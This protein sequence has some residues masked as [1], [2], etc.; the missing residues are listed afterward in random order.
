MKRLA[1]AVLALLMMAGFGGVARSERLKTSTGYELIYDVY[2]AS[3]PAA[4]I[5]MHGKNG[6]HITPAM[7]SFAERVQKAGFTVYLPR[8]PWSRFWDG[9]V[10]DAVSAVDALV[11]LAAKNGKKVFV[12]GQSQG[13][14]FTQVYRPSDPPPAVI[15]KVMTNPGGLLDLTSPGAT[16][17]WGAFMPSVERARALEK[18]GKGKDKTKFSGTNVQ[19]EKSIEEH[20]ETTPEIFLSFHDVTRYPSNRNSLMA[21][22]I[23]VFWSSGRKDPIQTGKRQSFNLIPTNP[24]SVYMDI[25]GDHNSAMTNAIDPVI[26]WMNARLA[27]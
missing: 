19:G 16:A 22:K 3:G 13:A 5:F 14:N 27:Q 1:I 6:A 21:T 7:K 18:D 10:D 20:Y 17:F 26:D 12:G 15:G 2:P 9:T 11:D 25:D 23:P 24:A 8:M 4:L